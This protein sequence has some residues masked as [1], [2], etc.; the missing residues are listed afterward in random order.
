MPAPR[1]SSAARWGRCRAIAWNGAGVG[2][3][4][5]LSNLAG[6]SPDAEILR[7]LP[8]QQAVCAPTATPCATPNVYSLGA[9]V[10][11]ARPTALAAI[12]LAGGAAIGG[13]AGAAYAT[14][15][16]GPGS[17]AGKGPLDAIFVADGCQNSTCSDSY[18][19]TS[20]SQL[21]IVDMGA[22]GRAYP[23]NPVSPFPLLTGANPVTIGA[24][25]Y[26]NMQTYF[27]TRAANMTAALSTR[28]RARRWHSPA[29]SFANA[30]QLELSDDEP[31]LGRRH[32][33]QQER[34]AAPGAH[35]LESRPPACSRSE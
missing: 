16:S 15:G 25:T 2:F 26:A 24:A 34:R 22:I 5:N 7:R 3:A 4:N 14:G 23:E 31:V 12:T 8:A 19:V 13:A 20:P 21:P 9:E 6:G 35:L 30:A 27:S 10:Q 33:H 29:G 18:G 32:L 11:V 1:R 28:S 17:L